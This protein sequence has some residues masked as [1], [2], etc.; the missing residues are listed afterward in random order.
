MAQS[1]TL[2]INTSTGLINIPS[3]SAVPNFTTLKIGGTAITAP[4]NLASG[5][6]GTLGVANGGTGITSFGSGVATWLNAPN[7]ANLAAATTNETGSG[8]L[9]F[10][11]SPDFTTSI[12]LGGVAVPTISSTHTLTNKTINGAN[13]TITI[14]LAND[15]TGT[16]PAAN[17]GTGVTS[18]SQVVKALSADATSIVSDETLTDIAGLSITIGAGEVWRFKAV[19]FI[20]S[21]TGYRCCFTG[22]Q[23]AT[24]SRF[25]SWRHNGDNYIFNSAGADSYTPLGTALFGG[26]GMTT[27]MIVIEGLIVN[28]GTANTISLQIAQGVGN[29]APT[30]AKAGS[31]VIATRVD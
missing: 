4:V 29:V 27:G 10:G 14:R 22:T 17:G 20:T 18:L 6:T 16:L 5:V 8:A 25:G 7:S 23:S 24:V 12:T 21:T 31:F 11:T 19:L 1:S 9:V 28:A 3:G 15:V 26:S 13:N 30:T 2:T